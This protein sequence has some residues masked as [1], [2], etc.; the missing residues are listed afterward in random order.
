MTNRMHGS[1]LKAYGNKCCYIW[2]QSEVKFLTRFDVCFDLVNLVDFNA[3][4]IDLYAVK[5]CI[6]IL[7]CVISMFISGRMLI[8]CIKDLLYA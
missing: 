3:I 2:F 6:C 4:S 1:D 7:F 8:Q 5:C